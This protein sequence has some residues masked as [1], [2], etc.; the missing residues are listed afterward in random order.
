MRRSNLYVHSGLLRCLL[1]LRLAA[2]AR[3]DS[4]LSLFLGPIAILVIFVRTVLY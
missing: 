4:F 2:S 1:R 3:N